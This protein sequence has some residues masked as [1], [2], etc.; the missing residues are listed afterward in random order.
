MSEK[1]INNPKYEQGRDS[2]GRRSWKRKPGTQTAQQRTG[3]TAA[4]H[5]LGEN[6]GTER[7]VPSTPEERALYRK[8][9]VEAAVRRSRVLTQDERALLTERFGWDNDGEPASLEDVAKK[10]GMT[11][12]RV[13]QI[14]SHAMRKV[15]NA[16]PE[17]AAMFRPGWVHGG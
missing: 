16:D 15:E 1:R 9:A 10:Y 5:A 12:E 11:R 14:E 4:L 3:Q 7:V 8:D 6:T 2:R 17:L 13:R